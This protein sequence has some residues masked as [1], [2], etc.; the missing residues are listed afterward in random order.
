MLGDLRFHAE[1]Q[2]EV[3]VREAMVGRAVRFV[4]EETKADE[5]YALERLR[6]AF[7]LAGYAQVEFELEPIA[8]AYAY[9][10]TL[11]TTN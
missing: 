2:Y 1:Q 8:A 4:G 3:P 10:S 9:E 7:E 6:H 5:A 11:T